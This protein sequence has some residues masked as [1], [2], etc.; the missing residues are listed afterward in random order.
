MKEEQRTALLKNFTKFQIVTIGLAF[1]GVSNAGAGLFESLFSGMVG[2]Q[3]C[4][5][6]ST[7]PMTDCPDRHGHNGK[8]KK[9][10]DKG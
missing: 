2:I 8:E 9:N 4:S 6:C 7:C 5:D 10:E 1:L 3:H